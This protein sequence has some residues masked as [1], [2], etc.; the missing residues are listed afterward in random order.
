MIHEVSLIQVNC[1]R[2]GIEIIFM[3]KRFFVY[4]KYSRNVIF[5]LRSQVKRSLEHDGPEIHPKK[6]RFEELHV[7]K[8]REQLAAR[9]DAP[10]EAS[11][12]VDNIKYVHC[13]QRMCRV[14]L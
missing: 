4:L 3:L 8:V 7:Q 6:A 14:L 9:L 2:D 11:V 13:I 1:C 10:K 12:T 5:I